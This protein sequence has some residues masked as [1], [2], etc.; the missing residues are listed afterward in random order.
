MDPRFDPDQLRLPPGSIAHARVPTKR[1]PRHR[2]GQKFLRGP[3]PLSW[4]SAACRLGGKAV[5]VGLAIWFKAGLT[6]S[7]EVPLSLSQGAEFGFDRFA[8]SRGLV[9][10]E[11][12]GLV[13]VNR[14]PGR[15]PIVTILDPESPAAG[16]QGGEPE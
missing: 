13:S 4:L 10:L 1:L 9:A 12:A 14:A 3:I 8:G 16:D 6:R 7:R 11:Q 5:H 15:K 2:K